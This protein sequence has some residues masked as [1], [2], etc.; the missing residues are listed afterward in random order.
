MHLQ[1]LPHL[2]GYHVSVSTW[3]QMTQECTSHGI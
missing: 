1:L 2:R 3:V